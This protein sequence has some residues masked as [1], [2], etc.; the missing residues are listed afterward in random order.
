LVER[1]QKQG[2][3]RHAVPSP[4][5]YRPDIQGLRAIAAGLVVLYHAGV[6]FLHGGYVGV[7]VFFV[8]SGFLITRQLDDEVARNGRP[9]FAQF[10]ARRARRL[11]PPAAIV[12][13]TT[14]VVGRLVLPYQ[15]MKDLATNAIFAGTYS[16]NYHLAFSGV[17]YQ[18]ASA[19]PSA[20]QHFWSLA[21][22]EQ[23]YLIWPLLIGLVAV[24]VRPTRARRALTGAVVVGLIGYTLYLSATVSRTNHSVGYFSLQTRAWEL[25]V[26]ALLALSLRLLA[27]VPAWLSRIAGWAGLAAV[28]V[29]AVMYTETTVYPG[30]AAV[31]PVGGA[32][33]IIAGGTHRN[34]YSVETAVLDLAPMQYVG[35]SSY[36]WYLWHWP[37]LILLPYWVGHPLGLA[38]KLEVVVLA[39]WFAILTYFVENAAHR[40][41]WRTPAWL[42]SGLVLSLAMVGGSYAT[43]ATL[44]TLTGSG[45]VRIAAAL[46]QSDTAIVQREIASSLS[47]VKLPRNLAPPLADAPYDVAGKNCHTDELQTTSPMCV[48]GDSHAHQVAVLLGD[49]KAHQWAHALSVEAQAAHWKV[50]E[51]TKAACPIADVHIWNADLKRPYTECDSFRAWSAAQV[52][53]LHPALIIASQ[54]D[55][56]PANAVNDTQ[57]GALTAQALTALAGNSARV[58]YIGDTPTTVDDT[59]TCLT[60]HINSVNKCAYRRQD[61][62]GG[63]PLRYLRLETA[64]TRAGLG[65]VKDLDWFCGPF[66]CPAVVDNMVVH[67]DWGH[68]TDAYSMWLA[69]MLAPVFRGA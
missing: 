5:R 31:L 68:I 48:L 37:M 67:R 59:T 17:Q 12:V 35:R 44:P 52:R 38:A 6:P 61:A 3:H 56:A 23:Y 65:Y 58:A 19:A 14:L 66:Y 50:I 34:P 39:L 46:T 47:I 16:L 36:A 22:E 28:I 30:I 7:D 11:L 4:R 2:V 13:L 42:A 60:Q 33:L 20:L 54:S 53:A 62:Y 64:L 27:R 1:A 32:A 57:W 25:G 10:Y 15:Q 9:R 8:I 18:N 45:S 55:T 40:S 24:A 29:S 41:A 49:S 26:G 21:V 69:P 43:A 63:F 51:M